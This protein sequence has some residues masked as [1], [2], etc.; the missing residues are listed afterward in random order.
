VAET[1]RLV[2]EGK[3]QIARLGAELPRRRR[4]RA[5]EQALR[6]LFA[7]RADELGGAVFEEISGLLFRHLLVVLWSDA[8][9]TLDATMSMTQTV[10]GA[11]PGSAHWRAAA[12][13]AC[14]D[15][16]RRILVAWVEQLAAFTVVTAATARY[17]AQAAENMS[18]PLGAAMASDGQKDP[19][20]MILDNDWTGWSFNRYVRQHF[21]IH[22]PNPPVVLVVV[23]ETIGDAATRGRVTIHV[24]LEQPARTT[25][26]LR[27][28]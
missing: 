7:R 4:R 13:G 21:G 3:V 1:A 8:L 25:V 5:A 27:D 19:G 22:L 11:A 26:L 15:F 24:D 12:V 28:P 18:L 14:K 2:G 17:G 10:P 9:D 23:V 6:E 16:E 20:E